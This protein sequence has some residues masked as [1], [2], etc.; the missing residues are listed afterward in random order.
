MQASPNF[1]LFCRQ[2][3]QHLYFGEGLY[4]GKSVVAQEK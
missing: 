1:S 3:L 2:M 4:E